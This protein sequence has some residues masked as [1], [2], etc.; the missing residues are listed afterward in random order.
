MKREAE[1]QVAY[2]LISSGKEFKGL[3]FDRRSLQYYLGEHLSEE[4]L[5]GES[6]FRSHVLGAW[7]KVKPFEVP[8]PA[9]ELEKK[10]FRYKGW[11]CRLDA[12]DGY[13]YLYTPD[14]LE[15]YLK[16]YRVNET[17][18]FTVQE[19]KEFIDNY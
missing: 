16:G 1:K 8:E 7:V 3:F 9:P 2:V 10:S 12:E 5:R 13:F 14:E 19:A 11:Y 4:F 17:E 6:S 18:V 15:N